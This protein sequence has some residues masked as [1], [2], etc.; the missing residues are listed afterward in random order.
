MIW[1]YPEIAVC[2][3]GCLGEL[4]A[5]L[6]DKG[7]HFSYDDAVVD[8]LV[9][10]SFS[11]TYGAR[12]LRRTIQKELEDVMASKIIDSYENPVTQLKAVMEDDK[13]ALLAM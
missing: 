8:Y 10:K 2:L 12:N 11:Q 1:N 4:Q 9:K 13:L 5:S 3:C 7:L 6:E